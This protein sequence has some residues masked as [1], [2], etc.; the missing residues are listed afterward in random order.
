MKRE[1]QLSY[2][3]FKRSMNINH[4]EEVRFVSNV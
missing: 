3:L 2:N 1:S 4:S